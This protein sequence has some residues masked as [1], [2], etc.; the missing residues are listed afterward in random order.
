M[1]HR[2][3][4]GEQARLA[5]ILFTGL[6]IIGIHAFG[7]SGSVYSEGSEKAGDALNLLGLIAF[8]PGVNCAHRHF[9][10]LFAVFSV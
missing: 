1:L 6:H 3:M 5:P 8:F 10:F 7:D 9:S 4:P 2:D